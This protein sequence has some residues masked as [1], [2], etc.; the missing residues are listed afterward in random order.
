MGNGPRSG[1]IGPS[2]NWYGIDVG[3]ARIDAPR[4]RAQ[5]R[6]RSRTDRSLPRWI[7]CRHF[8][9]IRPE[10]AKIYRR[11]R[12][13]LCLRGTGQVADLLPIARRSADRYRLWWRWIGH[14]R[15]VIFLFTTRTLDTVIRFLTDC[16]LIYTR[17]F[18]LPPG[19]QIVEAWNSHRRRQGRL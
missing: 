6:A 1:C 14:D 10:N 9:G 8:P 3:V 19:C 5:R 11:L 12:W 16:D 7:G 13:G 17:R 18:R 4:R 15:Y 2:H